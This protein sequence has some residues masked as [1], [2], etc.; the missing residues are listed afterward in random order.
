[1]KTKG[2]CIICNVKFV[3]R[4][5]SDKDSDSHLFGGDICKDCK[6]RG[7][8]YFLFQLIDK[9]QREL[10]T[11]IR[12]HAKLI[13]DSRDLEGTWWGKSSPLHRA[14]MTDKVTIKRNP[15]TLVLRRLVTDGQ[16]ETGDS[17]P[18]QKQD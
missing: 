14:L 5:T 17:N 15:K 16:S 12:E 9:T 1:M 4:T 18:T 6:K 3:Y 2:T 13:R 10:E 7:L 11:T 8:Q